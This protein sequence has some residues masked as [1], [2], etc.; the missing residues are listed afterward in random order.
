[1]TDTHTE[2][3][4]E[5]VADILARLPVRDMQGVSV[6]FH[7]LDIMRRREAAREIVAAIEALPARNDERALKLVLD[8]LE[9][10]ERGVMVATVASCDCD[11]EANISPEPEAHSDTCRYRVL[12]VA[13]HALADARSALADTQP[14]GETR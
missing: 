9:T 4:M 11:H 3:L 10:A 2:A 12:I 6:G 7:D 13:A 5:R 14:S 8:K 1:M